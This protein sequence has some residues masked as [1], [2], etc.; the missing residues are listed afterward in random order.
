MSSTL[1][2]L[3]LVVILV[4]MATMV[5]IG[6]RFARR[7]TSTDAYFVAKRSIPHWAL[8]ISIYAALISSITFIAYP[9]S[10]YAGN[11]NE[12]VPGFMVVGVLIL[13]GLVIIPF[14]RQAVGV[15]AYEYF[16]KRFGYKVR[17]Y[18]ALAFTGGHFSKM[19]F[20]VY[21]LSLTITAMTGW[22]LYVV[23]IGTGLVTVFYTVIGGL[24]AVIWTDVIQGFVKCIGIFVCLGFLLYLIPGGPG[25]AFQLA[26]QHQ[27][28]SL[29]TFD[30]DL[31]R[32]GSVWVMTLYGF[33]WYL[34]KY[35]ADQTL[36]QRY[37]VAKSDRE[38]LKGVALGAV[39]CIPAWVLFMLIGTLLWAYYQ[40]SGE[41]L[42]PQ[43]DKADKV[44]PHFLATKIPAGLAGLFM[45]SLFSAAMSMLSS[46]LN[47]LSAVGVEDYYRKLRP[48]S[49]DEQRLLV[50]K[51]I[52]AVCG[53]VAVL[54]ALVIAFFSDRVLLLYYTVTS[55]IA[56]GLAG[57]FLLAFLSTRANARG[58][59]AGIA[60]CLLFS[61]WATL[62]CG[63]DPAWDLGAANFTLHPI[64][65]GVLAHLVLLSVGFGVSFCF[66]PPDPASRALTLWGWVDQRR[67][68]R[69]SPPGALGAELIQETP[70]AETGNLPGG[71][72]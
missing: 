46:D 11:W 68:A 36:V 25:A 10:A 72:A 49:T 52:V 45:A 31:T 22:N 38:A 66:P 3:D 8:G 5:V 6:L 44:F 40:L 34:Q 71:A 69:P 42:P 29:G 20:V 65:I 16:G 55:I 2:W 60:A 12:L 51:L 28:F 27:K 67:T 4:Y 64:M 13:V 15:S 7:Q 53:T 62:T 1:R 58:A 17:A 9:G 37:L 50:G 41:V 54:I 23:L 35:T 47:C 39:L 19:G 56:G 59:Y 26:W 57:L 30:F 33:F 14:F 24:E 21:T 48:N 61:T 70:L 32:K 18:S 63:R 43:I